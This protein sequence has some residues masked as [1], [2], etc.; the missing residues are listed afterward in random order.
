MK[1]HQYSKLKDDY[2]HQKR[3]VDIQKY[4]TLESLEEIKL[5]PEP[6]LGYYYLLFLFRFIYLFFILQA[7][8]IFRLAL[9]GYRVLKRE[10]ERILTFISYTCGKAKENYMHL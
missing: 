5:S 9:L 6:I 7:E 8:I 10:G 2:L 4:Q 1:Y 3:D